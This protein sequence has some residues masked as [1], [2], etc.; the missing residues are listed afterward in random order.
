MKGSV[1][2]SLTDSRE[3]DPAPEA[4]ERPGVQGEAPCSGCGPRRIRPG[5]GVTAL[6]LHPGKKPPAGGRAEPAPRRGAVERKGTRRRRSF[7]SDDHARRACKPDSVPGA[8]TPMGDHS[9]G[10]RVAA[11]L[12]LPTRTAGVKRP[13]ARSLFGIAPGGACRAAPV[14][15]D[16][17][18]SYPTFSP[19]PRIPGGTAA[20]VSFLWRFPS[21]RSARALPGTVASGSPDFP[22][23]SRSAATR[24]SAPSRG[25]RSDGRR[26]SG[27][28]RPAASAQS[29][30]SRAPRAPGR[31]R[32]RKAARRRS[33]ATSG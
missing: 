30:A 19:L 5:R 2:S 25:M 14:A 32:R 22:R 27:R 21:D 26:Q 12:E 6:S 4:G 13:V 23:T 8:V 20:A 9:S 1:R 11:G 29:A 3:A 7:G 31:K 24:P 33:S 28:G 18:G 17:V 10:P 16:A 15:G